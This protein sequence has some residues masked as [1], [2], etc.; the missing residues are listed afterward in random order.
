MGFLVNITVSETNVEGAEKFQLSYMSGDKLVT[1]P[2]S[3]PAAF[4]D[5]VGLMAS[6]V[7][8]EVIIKLYK[9]NDE[10][11]GEYTVIVPAP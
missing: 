5:T 9:A 6:I 2:E 7:G 11:I 1:L 3:G 4:G 10:L 8:E